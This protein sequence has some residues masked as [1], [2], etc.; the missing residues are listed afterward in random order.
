M[1]SVSRLS[2]ALRSRANNI[3]F[4]SLEPGAPCGLH[5]RPPWR[6]SRARLALGRLQSGQPRPVPAASNAGRAPSGRPARKGQRRPPRWARIVLTA[7]LHRT[8]PRRSAQA[9]QP[10]ETTVA[11]KAATGGGG[12]GAERRAGQ[13]AARAG[14]RGRPRQPRPTFRLLQRVHVEEQLRSPPRPR[15]HRSSA[16][17]T[18]PQRQLPPLTAALGPAPPPR[19]SPTPAAFTGRLGQTLD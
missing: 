13:G 6:R 18:G 16:A 11:R 10:P 14:T 19:P 4:S 5:S 1:Y 15:P 12:P 8:R 3:S 9:L 17:P 7:V 2:K